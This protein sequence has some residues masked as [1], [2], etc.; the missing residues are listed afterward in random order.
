[1]ADND[2]AAAYRLRLRDVLRGHGFGWV[3]DQAETRIAEGKPSDKQVSERE[4]Y[5]PDLDSSFEERIPRRRR[6]KL[7]T[8]E[9]YTENESLE[10]MLDAIHAALVQRAALEMAVLEELNEIVPVQS[11]TFVPD[12]ASVDVEGSPLGTVHQLVFS[13]RAEAL[14]IRSMTELALSNIRGRARGRT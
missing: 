12:V 3:V 7:I 13:R 2:D 6:A 11:I 4:P 5:S 10:I 1:M 9:P 14:S 8:S